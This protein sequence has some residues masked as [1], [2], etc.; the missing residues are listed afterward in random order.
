MANTRRFRTGR[1]L[2][3]AGT[4]VL[5][6]LGTLVVLGIIVFVVI[7]FA[8]K[9]GK[10][11]DQNSAENQRK[12]KNPGSGSADAGERAQYAPLPPQPTPQVDVDHAITRV[13]ACILVREIA[14]LRG[15]SGRQNEAA[16]RA[17]QYEAQLQGNAKA[18]HNYLRTSDTILG[19]DEIALDAGDAAERLLQFYRAIYPGQMMV[20]T[21]ERGGARDSVI[22][23]FREAPRGY[24]GDLPDKPV[25]KVDKPAGD[26]GFDRARVLAIP[27]YYR[28]S[29]L[30]FDETDRLERA[31]ADGSDREW[32]ERRVL[33][34]LADLAAQEAMEF[35][36]MER[37]LKPEV[38]VPASE[39]NEKVLYELLQTC[40]SKG[41]K[42]SEKLCAVRILKLNPGF[43]LAR[44]ALGYVR[45]PRTGW[46]LEKS[47]LVI[48]KKPPDK[49][50]P[51]IDKPAD[52]EKL[53]SYEGSQYTASQLRNHL[54]SQGYADID[55]RW[56]KV[57]SWEFVVDTIHKPEKLKCSTSDVTIQDAAE[58]GTGVVGHSDPAHGGGPGT[59]KNQAA[60][61]FLAPRSGSGTIK[62]TVDAPGP[63]LECSLTATAVVMDGKGSIEVLA[64]PKNARVY[65]LERGQDNTPHDITAAVKGEKKVVLTV[66][67]T[68]TKE[69][70]QNARF[71][72]SRA[73]SKRV[74][75]L[76]GSVGT[77]EPKLDRLFSK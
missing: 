56:Y 53:I 38:P 25:A 65:L 29:V 48:A 30:S 20:V 32:V 64:G 23:Y 4:N 7:Q 13:N 27:A 16:G 40:R 58:E 71:L 11:H 61:R 59:I 69:L 21:V 73:D 67:M 33:G 72:P 35:D 9:I 39:K 54:R 34:E 51:K 46:R 70:M 75:V 28:E 49:T 36:A 18:H 22:V 68:M 19:V 77:P 26:S 76:S 12:S 14:R 10:V 62:I 74:F 17:S 1:R 63:I 41:H 52:T 43:S 6:W 37:A 57:S 3:S 66:K 44:I 24:G 60:N 8:G 2:S 50:D 47:D 5:S 31:L 45:D 42:Q 15:D 55:G